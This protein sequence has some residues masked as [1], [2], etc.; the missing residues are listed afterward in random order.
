MVDHS[1]FMNAFEFETTPH[2]EAIRKTLD[3]YRTRL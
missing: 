2:T 1:K 3:W